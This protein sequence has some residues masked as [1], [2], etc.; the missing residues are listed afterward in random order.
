MA[1]IKTDN[2]P[3]AEISLETELTQPTE[4]KSPSN[5]GAKSW[6]FDEDTE[7]TTSTDP[8]K[9]ETKTDTADQAKTTGPADQKKAESKITDKAKHAS[10]RTAVNMINLFQKGLFPPILNYK[11]QKK[12]TDAEKTKILDVQ[13]K[14]KKDL[15]GE[16]L[17]LRNKFDRLM[18]SHNKKIDAVPFT[19]TEE[20]DMETAFF[21][22]FDYKEKTLPPEWFIGMTIANTLGKR[23]IDVFTK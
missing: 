13:D 18:K 12:F 6:S 7:E 5:E 23:F 1:E 8:A 19:E 16:D 21:A 22:Y 11:F 2:I 17:Q 9:T 15:E 4:T 3:E 10:A 20:Q 14:D